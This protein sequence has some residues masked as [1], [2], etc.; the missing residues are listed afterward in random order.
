MVQ[1]N[2][3]AKVV[4]V[5][6]LVKGRSLVSRGSLRGKGPSRNRLIRAG[7]SREESPQ[8]KLSFA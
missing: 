1:S 5:K 2:G 4:A 8:P 3:S 7:Q 6:S